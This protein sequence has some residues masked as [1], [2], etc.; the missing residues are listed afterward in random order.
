MD[1]TSPLI[2][3][4]LTGLLALGCL[5]AGGLIA[6]L[7]TAENIWCGSFIRSGLMLGALWLA[8]PTRGRAAAWANVSPWWF[9]A[10]AGVMVVL[11]RYPWVLIPVLVGMI[12][13]MVFLPAR[14]SRKP[15]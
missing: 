4:R 6:L 12:A 11:V 10:L 14:D 1:A 7:D 9:V 3:R 8:L 2:N 15:R 13:L 5:G